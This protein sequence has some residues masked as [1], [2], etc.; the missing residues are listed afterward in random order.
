[1]VLLSSREITIE[2]EWKMGRPG[3]NFATQHPNDPFE[4]MGNYKACDI[5]SRRQNNQT[6]GWNDV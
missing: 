5:V 1:M 4:V 6:I 3:Q 2:A